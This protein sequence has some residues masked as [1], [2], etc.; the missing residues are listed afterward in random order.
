MRDEWGAQDQ[1]VFNIAYFLS[2]VALATWLYLA[3]KIQVEGE[4]RYGWKSKFA[5]DILLGS[6]TAFGTAPL[7]PL[8]PSLER[9]SLALVVGSGLSATLMMTFMRLVIM[10]RV[11]RLVLRVRAHHRS[12]RGGSEPQKPRALAGT[13]SPVANPTLVIDADV[14]MKL[15]RVR[16][17]P[18]AWRSWALPTFSAWMHDR[19]FNYQIHSDLLRADWMSWAGSGKALFRIILMSVLGYAFGVISF[20]LLWASLTNSAGQ[21][22][23]CLAG[24]IAVALF[25]LHAALFPSS[26]LELRLAG[27][28][29]LNSKG[30]ELS[31]RVHIPQDNGRAVP[32][33]TVEE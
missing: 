18:Y 10:P 20:W 8:I 30:Q 11:L 28:H 23:R 33:S 29:R 15:R 6:A 5:T 22:V 24:I 14:L 3:Y 25:T 1:L 16:G 21:Q 7:I 12:R 17:I 26:W 9:W 31:G 32:V 19:R 4:D 27:W 13:D 2:F